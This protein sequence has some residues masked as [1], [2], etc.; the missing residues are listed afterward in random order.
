MGSKDIGNTK[1]VSFD[2]ND[3]NEGILSSGGMADSL[4]LSM[5]NSP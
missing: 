2:L 1:V 3:S 4:S 5:D